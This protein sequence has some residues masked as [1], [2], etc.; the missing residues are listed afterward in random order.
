[1]DLDLGNCA[2]LGNSGGSF[3]PAADDKAGALA[4]KWA[5][6][7]LEGW[8]ET[9]YLSVLGLKVVGPLA[10]MQFPVWV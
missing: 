4:K 2:V 8:R 3:H 7:G 5:L 6:G 10:L 9:A 1:V